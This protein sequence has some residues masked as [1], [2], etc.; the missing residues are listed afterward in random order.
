MTGKVEALEAIDRCVSGLQALRNLI[1]DGNGPL[2]QEDAADIART[3]RAVRKT[4]RPL[5]DGARKRQGVK[6][7]RR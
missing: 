4:L 2:T 6:V 1:G 3:A 5:Y 7:Y